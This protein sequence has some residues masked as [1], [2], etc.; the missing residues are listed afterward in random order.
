MLFSVDNPRITAYNYADL[1]WDINPN[2]LKKAVHMPKSN[3]Y[4]YIHNDLADWEIGFVLPE[5]NS[6]RFF[7]EGAIKYQVKTVGLTPDH[8]V[9]MGGLRITPD[10]TVDELSLDDAAMLI[11]P[12]G[13][14][15]QEPYHAPILE[16]AKLCAAS[17]VAVAAICAA[18]MAIA[19]IGMLDNCKHTSNALELMKVY[20]PSYRGEAHYLDEPAVACGNLI[21]ASGIAPL[22]FAYQILKYLD[23][24]SADT[25]DAWYKLNTTR[26]ASYFFALLGSLS[27][28]SR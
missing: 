9:T 2:I 20:C 22:E 26:E 23:V 4:V 3:V 21:T 27:A 11:L 6:G 25:L 10:V 19:E 17:G 5:L 28:S 16:K 14:T 24:F 12:G 18:T 1:W 8:I 7:K 13:T 15:W